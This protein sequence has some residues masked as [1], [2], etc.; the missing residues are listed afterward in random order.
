V[1]QAT[2]ARETAERLQHEIAFV[3]GDPARLTAM[4]SAMF[5]LSRPDAVQRVVAEI[6]S[7]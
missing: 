4:R 7:L 3:I 2:E 6:V 1:V 5:G